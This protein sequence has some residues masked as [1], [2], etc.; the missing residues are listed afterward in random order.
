MSVSR[1]RYYQ[2]KQRKGRSKFKQGIYFPINEDKYLEPID[3]TMSKVTGGATYRS[4]WELKFYKW[5]DNNP[6]VKFW[7]TEVLPIKYL[8]P[9][10]NQIHRYYPDVFIKFHDETKVIVEIKPKS[11]VNNPINLAKF[12]AAEE[13][14]KSSGSTF[15]VMTEKELGIK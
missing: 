3:K 11:Q 2:K 12:A 9:K 15:V 10:D 1:P 7:G 8:S 6:K 13:Y 14:A 5:C 4:S